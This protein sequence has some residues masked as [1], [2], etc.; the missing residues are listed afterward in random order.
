M[1]SFPIVLVLLSLTA[2]AKA[3]PGDGN[4]FI[5]G[6]DVTWT[7]LGTN[8][9]DSMPIGNGDLAAN[10]WTE[11]NGD[12]VL[13]VAKSDAWSEN[14]QLL[15]P[16]RIRVALDPNPFTNSA[17]FTQT[18]KLETGDVELRAG[19]NFIRI[20]VDA[21]HPVVHVQ[22]Q[23]EAPVRVKAT[24]EVWRTKEYSLDTRAIDRTG[25]G[26]FGWGGYPDSL[27]FYPGTILQ[28][29]DNRV[30]SCHFNT[31]SIYPMVFEKEH[32]ESLL[33]DYPDPLMHRCFGLNMKGDNLVSSDNQT[34]KSLSQLAALNAIDSGLDKNHPRK[35]FANQVQQLSHV[36]AD[37]KRRLARNSSNPPPERR[38]VST[39]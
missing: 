14:G 24:S 38:I 26:F 7:T 4:P 37:R 34:L 36:A 31:H 21:N 2:V 30:S 16:G 11:Q 17:S 20:W 23:T 29:K 9:N 19:S 35:R 5:A 1:N 15:K 27:T 22:V 33:P 12:I 13:L 10:V 39:L 3:A 32:L 18:L 28:S 8:E 25:L 6:N